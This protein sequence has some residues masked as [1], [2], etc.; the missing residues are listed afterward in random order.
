[1]PQDVVVAATGMVPFSKQ[2]D[3]TVDTLAAGAV[4]AL[5]SSSDLDP[6]SIGEAYVGSAKGGSL[7]GQR[8]L[9]FAG[10]ANGMPIYN[11]ENAC[12]SSAVAFNLAFHAVREERTD[13]ALVV[14]VDQLSTL[15]KGALPVQAT[16][17]EGANGVTNPVVYAMRAQRYL[18]ETGATPSD[19]AAVTVKSRQF[20]SQ[21]PMAQHR[22]PTTVEEVLASRPVADPITLLQ[23]SPKS[24]GAAAIVLMSRRK[25]RA[26]GLTGPV[27]RASVVRSGAFSMAERDITRPDITLRASRAAFEASGLGPDDLDVVELHDAFSI[28]ELLYTEELG[29]CEEGEAAHHLRSGASSSLASGASAV[30]NPSGG[31]LSRGHP[32]GATGAAQIVELTTQ[33]QGQAGPRQREGARS[34][35]AH[36]TGGGASGFD[37]G[38]CCV[39]IL[40]AD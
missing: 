27:V 25:A 30:V 13:C 26:A 35:L 10:L 8:A 1:M 19:L 39:T 20:A 40:T 5:L 22:Q 15:G 28:A 29:L 6:R 21:N 32:I 34:G 24:D 2:A 4:R 23:C 7:V 31:L 12:A 3:G 33:L 36:V 16:E 11:V 38:A 9:R 17:W 14:G 37:N 18:H